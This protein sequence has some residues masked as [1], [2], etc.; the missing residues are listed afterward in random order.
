MYK[1]LENVR[2]DDPARFTEALY[3]GTEGVSK[4][5]SLL[6]DEF[7]SSTQDAH[8]ATT[9]AIQLAAASYAQAL[10]TPTASQVRMDRALAD[11]RKFLQDQRF[12]N[13]SV[14][15]VAVAIQQWYGRDS[16]KCW[17]RIANPELLRARDRS[18]FISQFAMDIGHYPFVCSKF[19]PAD[20]QIIRD[21]VDSLRK[22]YP[23]LFD[24][25]TQE[26][27]Y[28]ATVER[29]N[30]DKAYVNPTQSTISSIEL[31]C[32]AERQ[33]RIDFNYGEW[34]RRL[35]Q[36]QTSSGQAQPKR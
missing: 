32:T 30:N 21:R 19:A 10:R 1:V 28:I 12:S 24:V 17:A 7:R 18:M 5:L 13:A 15:N 33:R 8:S 27:E 26:R 23:R 29:N 20:G 11:V 16:G 9:F 25:V 22:Q 31:F 35:T 14:E 36:E 34:E 6:V 4:A 2:R 3:S